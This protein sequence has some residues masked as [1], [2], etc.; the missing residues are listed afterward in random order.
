MMKIPL[1]KREN[2]SADLTAGLT[3]SLVTIPEGAAY[4]V[5]ANVNPIYGL[6]AGMLTMIIGS[7]TASSTLMIVTLS[8]AI[9]LTGSRSAR[10][11]AG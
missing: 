10:R 7:L 4:A 11:A 2:L 5:V 1:P 9:A 3:V 6:Y 8:N